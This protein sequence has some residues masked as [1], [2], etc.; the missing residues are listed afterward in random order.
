MSINYNNSKV[1]KIWSPQGDKIYVGSTTKQYLSQRMTAHRKDYNYWKS[2]KGHF[3]TSYLLFDEYGLDNCFIEL[4]EAKS[5]SSKDE[6]KQLEGGYIRNLSC[7]NKRVENRS[8]E[9][10]VQNYRDNNREKYLEGCKKY[11]DNN[12]E[13][14]KQ[15]TE[16]NK[17]RLK[18][19]AKLWREENKDTLKEKQ[20]KYVEDNHDV[21]NAKKKEIMTCECCGKTYKRSHKSDHLKTKYHLNNKKE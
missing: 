17:E 4:L 9:E 18:P 10:S 5:C 6:L 1:Y 11:R 7:V 3:I 14:I 12:K 13:K 2:G 8:H 16:D 20:K 21:L 19:L 15:Y